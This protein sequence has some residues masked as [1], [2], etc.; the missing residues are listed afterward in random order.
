MLA[1]TAWQENVVAITN[2]GKQTIFGLNNNKSK[3]KAAN[4][5]AFNK[6]I[7]PYSNFMNR[8]MYF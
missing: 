2:L 3:S 5:L 1:G 7:N 8:T 4:S 6:D